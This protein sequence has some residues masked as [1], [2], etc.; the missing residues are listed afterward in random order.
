MVKNQRDGPYLRDKSDYS[1]STKITQLLKLSLVDI[2]VALNLWWGLWLE[3][4]FQGNAGVKK[5]TLWRNQEP[6]WLMASWAVCCEFCVVWEED[7]DKTHRTEDQLTFVILLSSS[8]WTRKDQELGR[9]KRVG[10]CNNNMQCGPRESRAEWEQNSV[11]VTCHCFVIFLKTHRRRRDWQGDI[12]DLLNTNVLMSL[13]H[14]C[15]THRVFKRLAIEDSKTACVRSLWNIFATFLQISNHSRSNN[16]LKTPPMVSTL[17]LHLNW[18]KMSAY[19]SKS[20]CCGQ[21]GIALKH[22][23]S[24]SERKR[25]TWETF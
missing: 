6:M 5:M 12:W 11:S 13:S 17:W 16:S 4:C 9:Q 24:Q 15:R 19:S 7:S 3:T 1:I 20:S 25:K 14:S 8:P 10:R 18:Y 22:S 2:S 23:N 21:H